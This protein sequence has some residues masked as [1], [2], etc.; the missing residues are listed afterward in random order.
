MDGGQKTLYVEEILA[1]ARSAV[2][3]GAKTGVDVLKDTSADE[4]LSDEPYER[5]HVQVL[6][7]SHRAP[8]FMTVRCVLQEVEAIFKWTP[9]AL[10]EKSSSQK[11]RLRLY[12]VLKSRKE[13]RETKQRVEKLECLRRSNTHP[14]SAFS[15]TLKCILR[16]A[17]PP[18]F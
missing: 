13:R 17:I 8:R 7:S 4:D 5:E 14:K 15:R 9:K 2:W 1:V 10:E 16:Y 3:K 6:R 18:H 12:K 11:R